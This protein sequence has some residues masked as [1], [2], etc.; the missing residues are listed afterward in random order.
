[1]PSTEKSDVIKSLIS[2]LEKNEKSYD[3]L[4]N[5]LE[6][7]SDIFRSLFSLLEKNVKRVDSLAKKIELIERINPDEIVKETDSSPV[8]MSPSR[9]ILVVDVDKKRA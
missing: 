6:E 2:L 8:E 5:K 4:T 9:S 1:M 7:N 3:F